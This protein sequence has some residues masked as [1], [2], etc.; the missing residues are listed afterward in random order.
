MRENVFSSDNAVSRHETLVCLD[1]RGHLR[2]GYLR[3]LA[4]SLLVGLGNGSWIKSLAGYGVAVTVHLLSTYSGKATSRVP[5]L[6]PGYGDG[7]LI[8]RV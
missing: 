6:A 3:F 5:G 2:R 1:W 8:I 7:A 4:G